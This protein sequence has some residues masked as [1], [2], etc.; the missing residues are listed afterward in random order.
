MRTTSTRHSIGVL[1]IAF[2]L[3][4]GV[5]AC[6][7]DK[8]SDTS[9]TTT[10]AVVSPTT[11][12]VKPV[13]TLTKAQIVEMQEL[14]DKVGCDVGPNDG[15]IGPETLVSLRAF[16]KSAGITVDGTYGPVT[17]AA[18]VAAVAAG[19][20]SCVLPTPTPPPVGPTGTPAAC[21]STA[22]GANLGTA[23]GTDV[24]TELTAFGCEAGWAYAY[25]TVTP[26]STS[27]APSIDVTAV[28]ASRDGK[29]IVQ[30]RTVVCPS[31]KMPASIYTNGCLSN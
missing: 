25:V 8:K 27:D 16:Q 12:G 3:M 21:T 7:S 31:G 15:V 1:V 17:K 19:K 5:A 10:T 28:L 29:W 18:L 14:L 20:T 11:S 23:F 6:G 9:S 26:A 4:V 24:K 22:V 2:A 30:D 13:S